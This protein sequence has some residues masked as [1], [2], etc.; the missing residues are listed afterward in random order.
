MPGIK[1]IE[2]PFQPGAFF[3]VIQHQRDEAEDAP[4][5]HVMR[6]IQHLKEQA[7]SVAADS[8][9]STENIIHRHQDNRIIAVICF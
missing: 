5:L 2:Q 3:P 6:V 7:G 9:G 8:P 1:Q 4:G